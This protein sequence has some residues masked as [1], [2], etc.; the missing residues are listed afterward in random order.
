MSKEL[1]PDLCVIGAG[2]GG[3]SV[4]AAAAA[5]GVSVV[6]IEKGEMGGE[7]LNAGCVPSKA[8]LA[9]AHAAHRM[10]TARRLGVT[11]ENVNVDFSAVMAHVRASVAAIAPN[12]SEARYRAMGVQ[13]IRAAARF[14]ARDKVEAGG[15][16]IRARRFVVATGSAPIV[17]NIPGLEQI[18]F[19]TNES[20]FKLDARPDHLVILG[21]GAVG[22]ELAQAFARLGVR[23][24][25]LDAGRAMARED[26]EF[27]DI[28]ANALRR[29]G[30]DLRENVKALR[31]EAQGAGF[32]LHLD[33]GTRVEG[34]HLLLATGRR[35]NVE[36]LGL[37]AA[38]VR[39]RKDGALVGADLRTSN[40][41]VYLIG[42]AAGGPQ[43]THAANYH[44]GLVLRAALFRLRAR[45]TPESVPRV[46]FTDPELA[47][48][49]LTETEARKRHGAIRVLRWPVAEN[50]RAR[51]EGVT[52]GHAKI[53]TSRNG[54]IVGAAI[55]GP[56]AG[57]LI[58]MWQVAVARGLN[59]RAMAGVVLPYP[60]LNE[61]GKRAAL[62]ALAPAAASGWLRSLLGLLR[63]FG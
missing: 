58:G 38:G 61:V 21:A 11:A 34:S 17:P 43:F 57:E 1:T 42:D 50:D 5:M 56:G 28:I 63:K 60:T 31:A 8:L 6:L 44:A 16:V 10:R 27:S 20:I 19:L 59:V 48:C 18:R 37:E 4:A 47:V 41:R 15:C 40:R 26:E 2:S 53:I 32:A 35:A 62:T 51:A 55:A 23:V 36:G 33:D 13:V 49:G 39:R 14:V 52:G 45:A 25:L 54:R 30:V 7:C 24:T 29:D 12:D 46:L 3:L 9:A 22:V